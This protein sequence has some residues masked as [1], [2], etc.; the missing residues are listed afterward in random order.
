MKW[1]QKKKTDMEKIWRIIKSYFKTLYFT[2]LESLILK[3]TND[4]TKSG[5]EA[6]CG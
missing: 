1:G 4:K 5:S 2:T 6:D 3:S